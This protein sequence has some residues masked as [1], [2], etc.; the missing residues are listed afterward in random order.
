ML[1]KTS[2]MLDSLIKDSSTLLYYQEG[3]DDSL[4]IVE[5][6]NRNFETL[7]DAMSNGFK[8]HAFNLTSD[9]LIEI[10]EKLK[11]FFNLSY[12]L[13][14]IKA[15]A[16]VPGPHDHYLYL[17]RGRNDAHFEMMAL[18]NPIYS[19]IKSMIMDTD[20]SVYAFYDPYLE[21]EKELI[22]AVEEKNK[23]ENEFEADDFLEN[24]SY[25]Q[26][27]TIDKNER[28]RMLKEK[29]GDFDEP[30]KSNDDYGLEF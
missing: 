27:I 28:I 16:V 19:E 3:D 20:V 17:V 25:M 7:D 11:K 30:K 23:K 14:K 6:N 9:K 24:P 1:V 8:I 18:V 13:G 5:N 15:I 4:H 2:K 12:S 22:A 21:K 26:T 10:P 29:L